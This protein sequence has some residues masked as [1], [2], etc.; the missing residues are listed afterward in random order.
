MPLKKF[1]PEQLNKL[2]TEFD[3]LYSI[4]EKFAFWESK[5]RIKYAFVGNVYSLADFADF[6]IVPKTSQEI[7]EFNYLIFEH[8]LSLELVR[9]KK[10]ILHYEDLINLINIRLKEMKEPLV[11]FKYKLNNIDDLVLKYNEFVNNNHNMSEF[12]VF[13]RTS[14][15]LHGFNEF[16]QKGNEIELT[17]RTYNYKNLIALHNGCETAKFKLYIERNIELLENKQTPRFQ[18][19]LSLKRQLLI[20]EYSGMLKPLDKLLIKNK[21]KI[22]SL[23]LNKSENSIKIELTKLQKQSPAYGIK[24]KENLQF[25]FD[26]FEQTGLNE[27]LQSIKNELDKLN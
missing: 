25:L 4:P 26:L 1:S 5:F 19:E 13:E 2:K 7:E 17:K 16:Y 3:S 27:D 14:F 20:L 21:E 24:T 10:K 12:E 6:L 9:P 15:W 8:A 18:N 22:L 11:L 23:L